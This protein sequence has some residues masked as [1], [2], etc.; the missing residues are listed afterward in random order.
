MDW[1]ASGVTTGLE[2]SNWTV[3]GA[4]VTMD[5]M[6]VL[7]SLV[8]I[9]VTGANGVSRRVRGRCAGES[10]LNRQLSVKQVHSIISSEL[11]IDR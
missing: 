7:D 5:T 2:I 9:G 3:A 1:M 8:L 4:R 10:V 6:T 11:H